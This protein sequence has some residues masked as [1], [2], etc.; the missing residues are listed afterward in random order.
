MDR[1]PHLRLAHAYR[2]LPALIP[3]TTSTSGVETQFQY[4][5]V[6]VNVEMTSDHPQRPRRDHETQRGSIFRNRYGYDLLHRRAR[7]RSAETEQT[8]RLKDGEASILAAW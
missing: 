3:S 8:I 6:G 2:L 4:I 1:R 7:H 5:D